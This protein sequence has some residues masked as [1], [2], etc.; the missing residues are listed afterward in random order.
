M[1]NKTVQEGQG[2]GNYNGRRREAY[3]L[4]NPV[5]SQVL[6]LSSSILGTHMS[7]FNTMHMNTVTNLYAVYSVKTGFS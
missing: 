7:Y 5:F 3:C 4:K 6:F 1:E 2:A